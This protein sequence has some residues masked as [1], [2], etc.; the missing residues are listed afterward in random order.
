MR[1]A[2][3][4]RDTARGRC[5]AHRVGPLVELEALQQRERPASATHCS[6]RNT[7]PRCTSGA[8]TIATPLRSS[9]GVGDRSGSA[10]ITLCA[11]MS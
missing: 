2:A 4:T 11:S 7:P 10:P 8:L 6:T 1:S 3:G 5:L 9:V